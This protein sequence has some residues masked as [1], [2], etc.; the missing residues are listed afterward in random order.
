MQSLI[1]MYFY[2]QC[3]NFKNNKIKKTIVKTLKIK[4]NKLLIIKINKI[5]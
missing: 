4:N 2:M 3:K 5:S 1:K